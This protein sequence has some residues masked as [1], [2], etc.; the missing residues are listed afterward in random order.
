M[1]TVEATGLKKD[2]E[3][4]REILVIT[5]SVLGWE[6]VKSLDSFINIVADPG[7]LSRIRLFSSRIQTFYSSQITE[8]RVKRHRIPTHYPGSGSATLLFLCQGCLGSGLKTC[9]PSTHPHPALSSGLWL[10]IRASLLE[11][12]IDKIMKTS[13]GDPDVFGPPGSVSQRYGSKSGSCPFLI[14]ALS[15]LK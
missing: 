14:K 11:H 10:R 9:T 3:K 4:W 2:V 5:D 12:E 7:Y 15:G 1:S 13:V 8:P 6:K